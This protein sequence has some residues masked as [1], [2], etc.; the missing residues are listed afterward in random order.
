MDICFH[1]SFLNGRRHPIF[2]RAP[3]RADKPQ[4]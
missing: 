3:R 4:K 1:G 2:C